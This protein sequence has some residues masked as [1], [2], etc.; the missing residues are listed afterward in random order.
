MSLS[1]PETT[2]RVFYLIASM[3]IFSWTRADAFS[4]VS[5]F[6][7][8]VSA[9]NLCCLAPIDASSLEGAHYSIVR[10]TEHLGVASLTWG[11]CNF[12]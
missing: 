10:G 6:D 3:L 9:S 12:Q 5:S 8:F 4:I 7:S 1:L 2:T 11:L